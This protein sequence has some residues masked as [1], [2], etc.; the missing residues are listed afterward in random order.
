MP[1]Q[2]RICISG[3]GIVSNLGSRP[4]QVWQALERGDRPESLDI[5]AFDPSEFVKRRY[6]RPLDNVTI[7][8]IAMVGAA[9]SEAG[10]DRQGVHP[11]RVGI[12]IG[13]MFAGIGCIFEFKQTCY[14]GAQYKYD[15]LSPLYFPG[16]VF[17]TISGQPAIEFGYTGPN[18]VI[19]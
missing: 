7:R 14:E 9:V 8:C 2:A 11:S 3:I 13:S 1:D 19:N 6:L 12:V 16:I 15:G 10:V 17:N 5:A 4:S 18:V